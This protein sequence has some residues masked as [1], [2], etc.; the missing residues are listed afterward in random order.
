MAS[1]GVCRLHG[2]GAELLQSGDDGPACRD[3]AIK[4]RI[5]ATCSIM[6]IG[7]CYVERTSVYG[8]VI[9]MP[10]VARSLEWPARLAFEAVR[11]FALLS[12]GLALQL[13][14]IMM[15]N[16]HENVTDRFSGQMFLCDLGAGC[17]N[18]AG[19]AGSMCTGPGGTEIIPSR[20]YGFD[21]WKT[22]S[23]VKQ[24]LMA[25]F[26]E[27]KGRIE[28][29][30]DPGEY[31]VE[32]YWCRWLCTFLFMMSM[33]QEITNIK[34]MVML[35]WYV[36]T[37]GDSW[38]HVDEDDPQPEQTTPEEEDA[39]ASK[40]AESWDESVKITIAGMPRLWKIFT[41]IFILVPKVC[42]WKLT[43]ET[44][45]V[46]L[47]ETAAIDDLIVNSVALTFILAIDEMMNE[48]LSSEITVD[49]LS[50]CEEYSLYNKK[51]VSSM[52]KQEI[53]K[54]FGGEENIG[55]ISVLEAI[56]AVV[57]AKLLGV[58]GL[59]VYFVF[60]YYRTHCRY[61]GGLHWWPEE[62]HLPY[63][64][65][66][67]LLNAMLPSLFPLAKKNDPIWQMP[68]DI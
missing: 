16:K 7:T 6:E 8:A 11:S 60:N 61:A 55:R 30:V 19:G 36:P 5:M 18:D 51:R 66:F 26:P 28:N 49:M 37:R 34:D 23:F 64:M 48:I 68:P 56:Q 67:N 54:E 32:S 62:L 50:R 15:L 42:I 58:V 44:G 38:V 22:R 53:L 65:D 9:V 63:G 52:S 14:I 29:L 17:T 57:P 13:L 43:A 27:D 31:G 47:M 10:Q 39:K 3:A 4:A 46:F 24:S 1:S 33:M 21:T 12:L 45:V 25:V 40:E 20:T 2:S 35:L 59:T 41:V